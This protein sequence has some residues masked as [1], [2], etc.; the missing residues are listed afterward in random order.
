MDFPLGWPVLR[1]TQV[2]RTRV[3]LAGHGTVLVAVDDRVEPQQPVVRTASGTTV[4]AGL[5]GH[6]TRIIPERGAVIEANATA[7]SFLVGFGREALGP[8]AIIP[9]PQTGQRG[10]TPG[11]I[12]VIHGELTD[13]L[14]YAA[15]AGQAAGI[16][17][18]SSHPQPIRTL[19]G[20]DPMAVLDG[21]TAVP[22]ELPLVVALA[23]GFGT[24]TL[25]REYWNILGAAN[26]QIALLTATT[27]IFRNQR[28][29][30]LLPLPPNIPTQSGAADATI[31]NGAMAWVV[32]GEH[33]GAA[34]RVIRILTNGQIM[35]S[36]IRA[37]S[38]LVHLESGIDVV[39]PLVNL[40]RVG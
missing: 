2:L 34:G 35:P 27:D 8:L 12:V 31:I 40:Q 32:G 24:A 30:L 13:E 7:L 3:L 5:Q 10:F 29:E 9:H 18:G 21:T 20:S 23:H 14:L 1:A 15:I 33:N 11:S 22:S 38:A 39:I 4:L 19:L 36:G 6:V 17:A 16:I 28:P 25:A 37:R 26:G